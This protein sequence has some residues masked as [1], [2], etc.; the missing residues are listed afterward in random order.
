M[1]V[2]AYIGAAYWFTSS[3]ASPTR[4]SP[5]AAPSSDSFAGIAPASVPGFVL[6]QLA[7]GVIGFLL[8]QGLFGRP[9]AE[10]P[11]PVT[12]DPGPVADRFTFP[13]PDLRLTHAD[14]VSEY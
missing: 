7:G 13:S 4:P 11:E 5:S 12:G 14:P 3:A 1:A 6:A 2:A 10:V 9:G 8:V